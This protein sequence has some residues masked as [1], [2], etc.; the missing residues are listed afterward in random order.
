MST[1]TQSP[2]SAFDDEVAAA[3]ADRYVGILNDASIALLT[4]VGHRTGLFDLLS[5]HPRH[6]S[7]ELA[8]VAGLDERYVREWLAGMVV[9]GIVDYEPDDATY[10]LPAEHA[11]VLTSAAGPDNIAQVM[12]YIAMM[13]EIEEKIVDRFRQ[14]GGLSYA[15][16][17]RFHKVM[18]EES[19]KVNDASLIDGILPL[20]DGL[21]QRL[22][23]GIDVADIGCGSGHAINLMAHAYPNSRFTGYDFSAEV[24][25]A[26]REEARRWGLD[27]VRFE[28]QDVTNLDAVAAFDAI[29]AFDAIHDQA[30]PGL[31][32]SHIRRALRPD[33]VF[34][35]VDIRAATRV[36]DNTEL[37]WASFIYAVSLY[38]CMTVSL[39]QGGDGLGTAWGRELAVRMLDEA[40][41]RDVQVNEVETDPFNLYYVARR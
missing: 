18:A 25:E 17:P 35:M 30:R 4:S 5:A 37:P 2:R 11:S 14:G 9:G 32:L 26:A 6:T 12:Q 3:F 19:A 40:G 29:T 21:P 13:G 41:F 23:E 31:V 39:G 22:A 7:R 33:G 24:I 27:N 8:A 36:E 38:H 1:L 28:V 16:Y 20:V 34:L 15:D 10:A